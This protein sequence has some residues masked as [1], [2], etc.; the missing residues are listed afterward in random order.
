MM[1]KTIP[2][3]TL[4]VV[5]FLSLAYSAEQ[6]EYLSP[7]GKYYAYIIPL[8]KAPTGSG[9]SEVV[10]KSKDNGQI[11]CSKNYG[12]EDG[13]H[14]YGIEKAAWTP[15]SMFFVYSMSS[16]G[17]HQAWHSPTDFIAISDFKIHRLDDYVGPITNPKFILVA[18]DIIKTSGRDKTILDEANFE[19][20]LNEL[21][22]HKM[23][24]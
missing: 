5:L 3:T 10:I 1:K 6:K 11:L 2:I 8:P 12:S 4:L 16:S 18:P 15:N 13:E 20:K 21:A 14:G 17:G 23:N 24:E 7:D 22:K 9:E 19:V